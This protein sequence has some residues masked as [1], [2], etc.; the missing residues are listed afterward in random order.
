MCVIY[1]N[2]NN[3]LS[4]DVL[5]L[6]TPLQGQVNDFYLHF[7]RRPS[8]MLITYSKAFLQQEGKVKFRNLTI[9]V[10]LQFIIFM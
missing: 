6:Q 3:A 5:F 2:K 9:S 8:L 4:R 10:T 1:L 7:V